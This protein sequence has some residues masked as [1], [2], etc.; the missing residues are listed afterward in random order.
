M[1]CLKILSVTAAVARRE[2]SCNEDSVAMWTLQLQCTSVCGAS[3]KDMN[4]IARGTLI[5]RPHQHLLC[6]CT[7]EVRR[8]I[9][10]LYEFPSFISDLLTLNHMSSFWLSFLY[11]KITEFAL[12]LESSVS[13]LIKSFL[14]S[15]RSNS[16]FTEVVQM[17]FE[18][19][20]FSSLSGTQ[21]ISWQ[22]EYPGKPTADLVLSE[23]FISQKDIQGIVPLSMVRC[24]FI[25]TSK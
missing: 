17:N 8:V 18:I 20:S 16:L 9:N 14:L 12:P 11:K 5:C 23:V 15:P 10:M 21:P 22:L 24:I 25:V 4:L 19:T 6:K 2:L 7:S 13:V 3:P 1:F